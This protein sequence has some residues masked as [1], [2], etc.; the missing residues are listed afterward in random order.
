MY[1]RAHRY[2]LLGRVRHYP[3]K[4]ISFLIILA[5]GSTSL[6]AMKTKGR[7][8]FDN[9]QPVVGVTVQLW[10]EDSL[11]DDRIKTTITNGNGDYFFSHKKKQDFCCGKK[12][13]GDFYIKIRKDGQTKF[14]S[15]TRRNY[16]PSVL[17]IDRTLDFIRF[18]F[19]RNAVHGKVTILHPDGTASPGSDFQVK[20]VDKDL[21][22]D[23]ELGTRDTNSSGEYAI[24]FSDGDYQP[25]CWL[26]GLEDQPNIYVRMK[27]WAPSV[28]GLHS[29]G[30]RQVFESEVD[31]EAAL[32]KR[33][34]AELIE[35][36][37]HGKIASYMRTESGTTQSRPTEGLVALLYNDNSHR[38]RGDTYLAKDIV[39]DKG[40]MGVFSL[41][42]F[43]RN[44][45]N[46]SDLY[47]VI[48]DPQTEER[49]W[50]SPEPFWNQI[51]PAIHEINGGNP[52]AIH[53]EVPPPEEPDEEPIPTTVLAPGTA[54]TAFVITNRS[55][56]NRYLYVD[57]DYY[58]LIDNGS[59]ATGWVPC[60]V[61]R[62][63]QA[64]EVIFVTTEVDVNYV[65]WSAPVPGECYAQLIYFVD[66]INF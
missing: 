25:C 52:V 28:E 57:G 60:G 50:E 63:L 20:A 1:F 37:V 56:A 13:R 9:G 58:G 7:I 21:G 29:G 18:Q 15:R 10:D 62:V 59:Q 65:T 45:P 49:I 3:T 36:I 12:R 11:A 23:D 4:L 26:G 14:R 39:S 17:T 53:Y 48:Y 16:R 55:G 30:H 61:T 44:E 51:V 47:V 31:E 46:G 43:G 27:K 24:T 34:D 33:V 6:N 32:P 22:P 41:R 42:A 54:G 19:G 5:L 8:I 64:S 38:G 35:V 66:Q 2:A 40:G